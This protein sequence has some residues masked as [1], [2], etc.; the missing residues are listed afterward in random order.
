MGDD[1][2]SA[3]RAFVAYC[4]RMSRESHTPEQ[5]MLWLGLAADWLSLITDESL[6]HAG[7]ELLGAN[8]RGSLQDG[9]RFSAAR[10]KVH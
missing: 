5:R 3:Y 2:N 4:A 10:S 6:A 1:A 8:D 9:Q 7:Q